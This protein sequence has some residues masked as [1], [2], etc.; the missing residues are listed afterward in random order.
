MYVECNIYKDIIMVH[1][2]IILSI[3]FD[4]SG[5]QQKKSPHNLTKLHEHRN[6]SSVCSLTINDKTYL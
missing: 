1:S 3:K 2:K 4:T 5:N 6:I